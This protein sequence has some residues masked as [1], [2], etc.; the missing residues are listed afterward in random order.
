[1]IRDGRHCHWNLKRR[2]RSLHC[3]LRAGGW[4]AV[5]ARVGL[6]ARAPRLRIQTDAAAWEKFS[7]DVQASHFS[8]VTRRSRLLLV[9]L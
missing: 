8:P 2:A 6:Q 1:M 9:E 4:A 3:L 7:R 5:T